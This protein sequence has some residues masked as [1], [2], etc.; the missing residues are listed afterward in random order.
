[1]PSV[2]FDESQEN[3]TASQKVSLP[4]GVE[5]DLPSKDLLLRL[6]EIDPIRRL[7]SVRTLQGIAFYKG[8]NFE[9]VKRKK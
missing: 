6:L 5:L 1:F 3:S 9:D 8:Y 4:D 2:F 7:R